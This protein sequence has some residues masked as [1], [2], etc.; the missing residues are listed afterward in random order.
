MAA[1]EGIVQIKT[2]E[3]VSLSAQELVDCDK[4]NKGCRAGAVQLAYDYIK[5]N[6]I[7]SEA[8]YPYTEKDG[9]C[10]SSEKKRAAKID[11]YEKVRPGEENLLEAVAQQPVTVLVAANENFVNYKGGIFG[12]GPCG[13]IESLKLSHAVTVIG[14]TN[15]YWLIKNSYGESWGEKGYMR[16]KRK[17]DSH[18][19]VCGLSMTASIYPTINDVK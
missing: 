2:G 9:K 18:Y 16:L 6:E 5:K 1:V 12:S 10:L 8:D 14:Y 13:P 19:N 4:A 3:L 17:G 7:A 15:E 11:G